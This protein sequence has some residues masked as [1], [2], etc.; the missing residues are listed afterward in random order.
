MSVF[1]P[2]F[3]LRRR[4]VLNVLADDFPLDLEQTRKMLGIVLDVHAHREA[5][6]HAKGLGKDIL[7]WLF[8]NSAALDR[9]KGGACRAVRAW[10][11]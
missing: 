5:S 8:R 1:C 3:R 11:S 4:G 2:L 6:D 9:V 10:P 7:G